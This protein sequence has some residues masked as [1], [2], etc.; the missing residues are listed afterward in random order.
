MFFLNSNGMC[1]K[2]EPSKQGKYLM[3]I[4]ANINSAVNSFIRIINPFK[5]VICLLQLWLRK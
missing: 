4:Y 5:I 3:K 2:N 1:N